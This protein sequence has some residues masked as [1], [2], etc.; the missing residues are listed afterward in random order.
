MRIRRI[1][2]SM[3]KELITSPNLNPIGVLM[4]TRSLSD[5][6]SCRPS[7]AMVWYGGDNVKL[8]HITY[9]KRDINELMHIYYY[10]LKVSS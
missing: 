7:M 9:H 8:V 3:H 2:P 6:G 5:A 1:T 10:L 4:S